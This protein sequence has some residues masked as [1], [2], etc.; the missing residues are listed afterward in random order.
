MLLFAVDFLNEK[1]LDKKTFYL[2][3][4]ADPLRDSSGNLIG[5]SNGLAEVYEYRNNV[6]HLIGIYNSKY[7]WVTSKEYDLTDYREWSLEQTFMFSNYKLNLNTENL[8]SSTATFTNLMNINET[9]FP[10]E[11][12]KNIFKTKERN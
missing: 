12:M 7:S 1:T 9:D 5:D 2:N 8:L 3:V 4:W 10:S 6:F 11:I